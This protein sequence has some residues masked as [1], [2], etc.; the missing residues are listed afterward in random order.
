MSSRATEPDLELVFL[1]ITQGGRL[2]DYARVEVQ[3]R[4]QRGVGPFLSQSATQR[5]WSRLTGADQR[6]LAMIESTG[7]RP[8]CQVPVA[9]LL[10]ER[11][12]EV[13]VAEGR[14][15]C[16][17][18]CHGSARRLSA[19]ALE[20]ITR[21]MQRLACSRGIIERGVLRLVPR[22]LGVRCHVFFRYESVTSLVRPHSAPLPVVSTDGTLRLRD[23]AEEDRLLSDLG[24]LL[25]LGDSTGFRV[26]GTEVE[27]LLTL[28]P[29]RWTLERL[30][31]PSSG[32]AAFAG[33]PTG[34]DWFDREGRSAG[35]ARDV[36]LCTL[37]AYL[38]D[39]CWVEHNG[40]LLLLEAESL[41]RRLPTL[42][43]TYLTLV[44]DQH[45]ALSWDDLVPPAKMD[46]TYPLKLNDSLAS[47]AFGAKLR[48]YQVEGVHWLGDR[49]ER[50]LGAL[51]A[52]EM[53]LGKTIQVL[54]HLAISAPDGLHLI[55][56]PASVVP[57]WE[58]ELRNRLP[59]GP[60]F[61]VDDPRGAQAPG[62]LIL[63][64]AR[65]L[66]R[67][68]DIVA[69]DFD[70]VVLDEGQ[71]A[72]N[73]RT[74]TAIAVRSIPARQRLVLTGTPIEN[75]VRELWAHMLFL[76]PGLRAI[77]LALAKLIPE[78]DRSPR[79]ARLSGRLLEP[80]ILRRTKRGVLQDLPPLI[81]RELLCPLGAEQRA[82]YERVRAT[83]VAGLRGVASG[84]ANTLALEALLR[85]RQCCAFPA[86]LPH[87]LNPEGVQAS[88]KAD[89]VLHLVREAV[90][91]GLK[92]IIFSQFTGVLDYF[93]RI[94]REE[95]VSFVRLDGATRNREK[96]VT[97][98]QRNPQV[99]VF[100][101]AFRA[102]NFG[103]NLTAADMVIICDPWWNP[104]AEGQALAR[105]HRIG[106]NERVLVYR[107]ICPDTI[108]Q[109]MQALK[110]EKSA[111]ADNALDWTG[112]LTLS[113]ETIQELLE[114]ESPR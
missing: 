39:K 88:V 15:F 17:Q 35:E 47:L 9:V 68:E 41:E 61:P 89:S 102:G 18:G 76:N 100:V 90:E 13:A 56:C 65:V 40:E 80:L 30:R 98:F 14:I 72:K 84:R 85:L 29:E 63:S 112:G 107:C 52:D 99:A 21:G 106:R 93:C 91:N 28:A 81:E 31:S 2:I 54:A 109:R 7:A 49:R 64:Y 59:R 48:P 34:I 46:T 32:S 103:I 12:R 16:K 55:V 10:N 45:D 23:V 79:A 51:L 6:L 8:P 57:N 105:A 24:D 110:A 53:G 97:S 43:S 75:S 50:R 101:C 96:P 26:V 4:R 71:M 27:R 37:E 22:G 94:F 58:A 73:E 70:T 78:F 67:A 66:S 42:V 60:L 5:L 62:V 1:L 33:P 111:V 104:A 86:L 95:G 87:V 38:R 82:L 44:G 114:G 36:L 11:I 83:F 92:T 20:S 19:Q 108:E 3:H 69:L 113:S 77:Y 25:S 74:K